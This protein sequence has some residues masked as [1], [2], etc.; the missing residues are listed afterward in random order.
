MQLTMQEPVHRVQYRVIYG[1]TDAAGV[2]YNANY[3]RYFEIGR[4]EMMRDWVCSYR[5]IEKLGIV[6]PVT[7]CFSRFKAPAWYDDLITIETSIDTLKK[8]SIRIHYR[9]TRHDPELDRPR[10]LVKGYT[11]HASVNRQGRLT[12]LPDEIVTPLHSLIKAR[13][14]KEQPK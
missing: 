10:L 5:D 7:E 11:I 3:L 1:D 9:I 12:P 4:T 8:V 14:E 2:V 6:L 13:K